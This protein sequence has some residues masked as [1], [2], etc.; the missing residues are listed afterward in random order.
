VLLAS[1]VAAAIAGCV[2]PTVNLA[3]VKVEPI[4]MTI[5]VNLH[6]QPDIHA[7]APFTPKN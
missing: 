3:P 1:L 7:P 5:D 4:Q 2:H 6:N